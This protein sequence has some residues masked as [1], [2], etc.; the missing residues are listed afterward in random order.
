LSAAGQFSYTFGNVPTN[1]FR[2]FVD[3]LAKMGLLV[4]DDPPK[5]LDPATRQWSPA[6]DGFT[7]SVR[8]IPGENP[9]AVSAI[10]I[11]LRNVSPLV[12]TLEIPNWLFFYH[13]EIAGCGL[14]PYG[15][16][17]LR[18]ERNTMRQIVTLQ[19]GAIAETQIPIGAIYEIG[20]GTSHQISVTCRTPNASGTLSGTSAII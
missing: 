17:L 14:T 3:F 8:P 19:P 1:A 6:V 10:S 11:A 16:A 18:P 7:I 4:R 2:R 9:E 20:A 15:R 12:A 5:V 13:I